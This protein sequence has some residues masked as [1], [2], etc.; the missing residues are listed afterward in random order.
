MDAY[1]SDMHT[2]QTLKFRG[3][4][5]PA[6]GEMSPTA[7]RPSHHPSD[8][9]RVLDPHNSPSFGARSVF[10]HR[11]ELGV[12]ASCRQDLQ[13]TS[14]D[15]AVQLLERPDTAAKRGGAPARE[16]E[17]RREERAEQQAPAPQG[18]VLPPPLPVDYGVFMQGLTQA[19]TQAVLQAQLDAQEGEMQQYLE[20]KKASQKRPAAM[21]QQQDKKKAVY[22]A[23]QRLVTTSS[24]QVPSQ[25]SPSVKKECPHC[26][27]THGLVGDPTS[28][29]ETVE[30]DS[31]RGE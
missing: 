15:L 1:F 20:E 18:P 16:D 23:P 8:F 10:L 7:I 13:S 9:P 22:Q 2:Q 31:E 28:L 3:Q 29:E 19:H 6:I 27:K 21:F 14:S 26:M 24:A 5:S 4:A 17:P 25:R 30:S 12:K 11:Q